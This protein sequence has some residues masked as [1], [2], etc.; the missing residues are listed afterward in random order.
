LV[1]GGLR[2][3]GLG[4]LEM[5]VGVVGLWFFRWLSSPRRHEGKMRGLL[6]TVSRY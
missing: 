4:E 5:G 1:L 6:C 3:R 2:Y